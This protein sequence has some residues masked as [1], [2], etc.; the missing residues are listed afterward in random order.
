MLY[1]G[2]VG[3]RVIA[4]FEFCIVNALFLTRSSPNFFLGVV[5]QFQNNDL[6]VQY[7]LDFSFRSI[8]GIGLGKTEFSICSTYLT[9]FRLVG[10]NHCMSRN[11]GESCQIVSTETKKELLLL[12]DSTTF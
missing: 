7:T 10:D 5:R 6:C 9:V 12:K 3:K 2:S 1:P 8:L 11:I 4:Y